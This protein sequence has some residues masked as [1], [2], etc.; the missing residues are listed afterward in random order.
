M[1]IPGL[2]SGSF[3]SGHWT[4]DLAWRGGLGI[5]HP[6]FGLIDTG[7]DVL[8]AHGACDAMRWR[9]VT[10]PCV[11]SSDAGETSLIFFCAEKKGGADRADVSDTQATQQRLAPC[12]SHTYLHTACRTKE[13]AKKEKVFF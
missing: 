3:L 8:H 9:V 7:A 1:R 6:S 10:E 11:A 4:G 13:G 12:S 2:D 5:I